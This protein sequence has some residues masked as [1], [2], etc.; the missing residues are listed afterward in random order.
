LE[1]A[2]AS[3]CTVATSQHRSINEHSGLVRSAGGQQVVEEHQ[4]A[5]LVAQHGSGRQDALAVGAGYPHRPLHP[6]HLLQG[7]GLDGGDALAELLVPLRGRLQ[8]LRLVDRQR[9]VEGV[10][11]V[12]GLV[13]YYQPY[14]GLVTSP[15][16][17][18][19]GAG[20]R[21]ADRSEACPGAGAWPGE[22]ASER[23]PGAW[24]GLPRAGP[25]A[26]AQ[27]RAQPPPGWASRAWPERPAAGAPV[28]ARP[29]PEAGP[30]SA[31]AWR[32]GAEQAQVQ[33]PGVPPAR[34]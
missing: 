27:P 1:T 23:R 24:A 15:V 31:R 28:G 2:P 20:S 13:V 12:V 14:V 19:A 32:P 17:K 34:G 33:D 30:R 9:L 8:G 5:Q 26:V 25:W 10:E 6:H 22:A 4:Q 29:P 11:P 3:T 16:L 7:G 21:A 18:T